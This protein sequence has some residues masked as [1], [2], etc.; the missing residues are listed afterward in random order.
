MIK[1]RRSAPASLSRIAGIIRRII[2]VPDY[3][4]YLAHVESCHPDQRPLTRDEFIRQRLDDR[5]SQPGARC[6]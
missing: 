1:D 6:C 5:Y 4:H 3:E 2:G